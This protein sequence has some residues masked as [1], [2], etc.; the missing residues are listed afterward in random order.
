MPSLLGASDLAQVPGVL[1]TLL[2]PLDDPSPAAWGRRAAHA[3]QRL[4]A[5]DGCS[6]VLDAPGEQLGIGVGQWEGLQAVVDAF[7]DR[8]FGRNPLDLRRQQLGARVWTRNALLPRADLHRSAYYNEWC[9]PNRNLDS[10]GISA[11]VIG[12]GRAE[13]ALF[14]TAA[15]ADRFDRGGREEQLLRLL[16]PAFAA[17]ITMLALAH[18]WRD[19]LGSAI[20]LAGTPLAIVRPDGELLHATPALLALVAAHPGGGVLLTAAQSQA[21]VVGRLL[22]PA[23]RGPMPTPATTVET[24]GGRYTLRATLVQAAHLTHAPI[25]LVAVSDQSAACPTASVLRTRFGLTPR[26]AEVTL[27]LARGDRN[28]AIAERLNISHHTVRRHVE[29]VLAKLGVH[30]RAAVADHIRG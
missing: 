30:A 6:I 21:R 12:P 29:H 18:S 11:P 28:R 10:A 2:T 22:D 23:R 27:L 3:V 26:E 8:Y 4:I 25:V 15:A 7:T 5:A 19:A 16:Q 14:V 24:I 1:T 13:G 17:G 9:R 20:D